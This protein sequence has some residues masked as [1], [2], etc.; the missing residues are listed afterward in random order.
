L[1]IFVLNAGSSTYKCSLFSK[2]AL[3]SHQPEEPLWRALLEWGQNAHAVIHSKGK[4]RELTISAEG[5]KAFEELLRDA[6]SGPDA[7]IPGPEAIEAAGHRV[8]HGGEKFVEPSLINRE[9]IKAIE[10]MSVLAPLHN[11]ENLKGIKASQQLFPQA[12]QVAV[13]DTAFHRNMPEEAVVYPIP[14]RW[15]KQKIRRYGFHGI[16]HQYCTGKAEAMLG[17]Q[18]TAKIITCHLGNGA[19]LA[20]IHE[21]KSI[22]TTMGFTPL[23]GL[24]MGTRS[25]S[26]DPGV[27]L[28]LMKSY[29]MDA[30]QLENMLLYESGLK[31]ICG[32]EDMRDVIQNAAR[33]DA[34][35]KLAFDMY[36]HSVRKHI[37]AMAAVLGGIDAL[38]FTGGIGENSPEIR[39]AVSEK[40]RFLEIAIDSEKNI[41]CRPDEDIAKKDSKAR[42][43]VIHTREDWE[44]ARQ[45][46]SFCGRR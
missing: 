38:I 32:V 26:V 27:L 33:G 30:D 25:G 12:K 14:Y 7:V 8:V 18:K 13:F 28:H 11:V 44:I 35:A 40:I 3:E 42:L 19:S 16:S 20:A 6:W 21:G 34:K 23:E 46:L 36:V 37:G 22:D 39:Q 29:G 24:M 4:R 31:G 43:L 45:A 9:T 10:E 15:R 17:Q 2:Q 41:S 1:F 5:D